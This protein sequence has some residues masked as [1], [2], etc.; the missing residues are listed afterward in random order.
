MSWTWLEVDC[1]A[2]EA[3]SRA[4]R[5]HLPRETLFAP[6]V[7]SE[8]YGHGLLIAARAFLKGGADWLCVHSLHEATTLRAAGITAPLY[9]FGPV[10]VWEL[11]QLLSLEVRFVLYDRT[12]L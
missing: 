3:N 6:T 10:G 7:K 4:L 9:L 12:L 1:E 11:E 5:A 2:L 8:G